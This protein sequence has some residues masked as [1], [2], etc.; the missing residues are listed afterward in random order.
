MVQAVSPCQQQRTTVTT[1]HLLQ[2]RFTCR[3]E[4]VYSFLW[5][6]CVV[7]V[8]EVVQTTNVCFGHWTM[9]RIGHWRV[10]L[11]Y[12]LVVAFGFLTCS[13]R[14]AAFATCTY[15]FLFVPTSVSD[16]VCTCIFKRRSSYRKNSY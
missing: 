7:Q 12:G 6:F 13:G 8:C 2:A 14:L 4:G 15:L 10:M 5:R 16:S 1:P 3:C 11:E 9:D